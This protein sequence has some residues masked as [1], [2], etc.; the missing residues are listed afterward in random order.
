MEEEEE[1]EEE[2]QGDP[3]KWDEEAVARLRGGGRGLLLYG[4]GERGWLA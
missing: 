1:E 3:N 2:P 4:G